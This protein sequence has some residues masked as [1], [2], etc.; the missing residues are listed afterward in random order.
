MQKPISGSSYRIL[1]SGV[2]SSNCSATN[3]GS[4]RACCSS[5]ATFA[6]PFGLFSDVRIS[7]LFAANDFSVCAI[8]PPCDGLASQAEIDLREF[9][10]K[11]VDVV[12]NEIVPLSE[13]LRQVLVRH[14]VDGNAERMHA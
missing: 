3:S 13:N 8:A 11:A 4:L 9:V 2:L 5:T 14:R 1:R 7:R 12:E 6:L 10:R